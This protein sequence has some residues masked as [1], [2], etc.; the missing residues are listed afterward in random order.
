MLVGLYVASFT[1]TVTF[2][3]YVH[4]A[5]T[6]VADDKGWAMLTGQVTSLL[7]CLMCLL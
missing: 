3:S 5:I 4:H 1:A 2:L 6:K 7:G